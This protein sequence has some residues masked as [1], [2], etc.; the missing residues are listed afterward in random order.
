MRARFSA[1]IKSTEEGPS[2]APGSPAAITT[3][4]RSL[5]SAR[6]GLLMH[7][8]YFCARASAGVSKGSILIGLEQS[9]WL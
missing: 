2:C 6:R 7:S 5:S 3:S 8:N 1:R 9:R 4:R